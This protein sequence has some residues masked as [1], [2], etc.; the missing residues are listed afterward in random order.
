MSINLPV[1]PSQAEMSTST[2]VRKP[3]KK[4]R[5]QAAY[6][7]RKQYK[8]TPRTTK[9]GVQ[10]RAPPKLA[11]KVSDCSMRY[12]ATL[13]NPF[14]AEPGAC[15]PCDLF[16]LPSQKIRAFTRGSFQVGTGGVG[17]I[18][19]APCSANNSPALA[20]TQAASV[21]DSSI[22]VNSNITGNQ[23]Q[24]LAGLPYTSA[25]VSGTVQA[26]VVAMGLR[27]RYAGTEAGRSGTIIAYEDQDHQGLGTPGGTTTNYNSVQLNSSAMASRPSG[28]GSWDAT[29]CSSGPCTPIELEFSNNGAYPHVPVA[30]QTL[31]AAAY[32]LIMVKGIAGDQYDFEC[33][34][35]IEYIGTNVQAKTPSHA[36]T[37]QY[38][39]IIQ[40]SKEIANI[41]PLTPSSGPGLFERF[42]N[43]VSESL[44]Q[45][46]E[47]GMGAFRALEGDPGGYAQL[48]GG[49]AKM[50]TSSGEPVRSSRP[51]RRAGQTSLMQA[52][53]A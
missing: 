44:P 22:N 40:A 10:K 15:V 12:M 2:Y 50:I 51:P 42:S 33:Y 43:K 48:L 37:A 14:Q 20:F 39:S 41:K 1:S 4:A 6:A 35:H 7:A 30:S 27:V 36:D 26:R 32:L 16:P 11:L 3:K 25:Q 28:D 46:I 52:I 53:E 18:M 24:L 49:A 31:N 47:F 5:K 17:F 38:G 8:A 9:A 34:E 21:V 13:C 23:T 29:V 45:L 19:A